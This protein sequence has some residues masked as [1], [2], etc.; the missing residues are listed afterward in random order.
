MSYYV[1]NVPGRL[2]VKTPTLKSMA[3]GDERVSEFST[4]L[5]ELSA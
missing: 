3:G 2:R 4:I 5:R 1:H